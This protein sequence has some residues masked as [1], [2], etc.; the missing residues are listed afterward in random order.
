MKQEKK[1]IYLMASASVEVTEEE[2]EKLRL[3]A[4]EPGNYDLC[5][6]SIITP[7]WLTERLISSGKID[8]EGF[9]SG[10]FWID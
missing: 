3:S 7:D 6:K 9:I 10:E 4:Y 8:G 2:Y 1:I 5:Y